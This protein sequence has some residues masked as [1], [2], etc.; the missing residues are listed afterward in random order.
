PTV[1]GGRLGRRTAARRTVARRSGRRHTVVAR[2]CRRAGPGVALRI[3]GGDVPSQGS[4]QPHFRRD[5]DRRAALGT[6]GEDARVIRWFRPTQ[7]QFGIAAT[8]TAGSEFWSRVRTGIAATVG[9]APAP[10]V[11]RAA[12]CPARRTAVGSAGWTPFRAAVP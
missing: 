4:G 6:G 11:G 3:L 2:G 1:V 12:I 8:A 10:P 7:R 9:A 5:P